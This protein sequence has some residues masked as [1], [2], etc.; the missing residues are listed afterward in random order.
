MDPCWAFLN[1]CV[2]NII[3]VW[4][5]HVNVDSCSTWTVA[6][7]RAPIPAWGIPTNQLANLGSIIPR[8]LLFSKNE[9]FSS[10]P[11]DGPF[12]KSGL[13]SWDLS[14]ATSCQPTHKLLFKLVC[15]SWDGLLPKIS[16]D[17][18]AVFQENR[19]WYYWNLP[20]LYFHSV[21]LSITFIL[22]LSWKWLIGVSQGNQE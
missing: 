15:Q 5:W 14:F 8:A 2:F 12:P 21:I 22:C 16:L 1:H 7:N 18:V 11:H 9:L 20:I 17:N 10:Q 4:P 19:N 13:Q 6:E 3:E